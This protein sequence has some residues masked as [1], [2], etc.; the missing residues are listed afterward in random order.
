M[1]KYEIVQSELDLTV[2]ELKK[3]HF[4]RSKQTRV[5]VMAESTLMLFK[6]ALVLL[7]NH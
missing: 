1:S 4:F 5:P 2:N 3:R 7:L 6:L